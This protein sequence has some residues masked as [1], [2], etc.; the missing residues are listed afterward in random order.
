MLWKLHILTLYF[1]YGCQGKVNNCGWWGWSRRS[2]TLSADILEPAAIAI[3]HSRV[4]VWKRS[5]A[6]NACMGMRLLTANLAYVWKA[7]CVWG[8]TLGFTMTEWLRK[9]DVESCAGIVHRDSHSA[10]YP[11]CTASP[12]TSNVQTEWKFAVCCAHAYT[13]QYQRNDLQKV[14]RSKPDQWW[15]PCGIMRF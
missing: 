13:A 11:N 7:H 14:V 15:H 10:N 8:C 4:L 1:L 5:R 9:V 12:T 6:C 2:W 3:T